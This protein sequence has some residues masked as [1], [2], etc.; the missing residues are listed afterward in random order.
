MHERMIA[1]ESQIAG[2]QQ[3][4]EYSG[5][6]PVPHAFLCPITQD[7]MLD[8]VCT[9]D[10]FTYERTAIERWF[11]THQTSPMTNL[12]LSNLQLRPNL[13]LKEQIDTFLQAQAALTAQH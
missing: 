7:L 9:H 8:P 1:Q 3:A 2:E 12:P 13:G 5:Q 6:E 10:N 11:E 4:V